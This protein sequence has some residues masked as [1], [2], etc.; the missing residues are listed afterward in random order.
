MSSPAVLSLVRAS[1][2]RRATA[3]FRALR[4]DRAFLE[5]VDFRRPPYARLGEYRDIG[6]VP[7][8]VLELFLP[9]FLSD[10]LPFLCVVEE[11]LE[12]GDD[13]VGAVGDPVGP[14]A[15]AAV[16]ELPV[17]VPP[18]SP[19]SSSDSTSPSFVPLPPGPC[20]RRWGS[21]VLFPYADAVAA[22]A[23]VQ[24]GLVPPPHTTRSR[25]RRRRRR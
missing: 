1:R 6:E 15:A 7:D 3:R 12:D 18:V 14:V 10:W 25:S 19:P 8:S 24:A 4:Q 21:L 5:V 11:V 2:E 16:D 17:S 22:V 23:N 20:R 13:V 9:D